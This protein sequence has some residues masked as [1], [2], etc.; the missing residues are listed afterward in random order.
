MCAI[1]QQHTQHVSP[2]EHS[3]N[4]TLNCQ[5]RQTQLQQHTELSVQTNSYNNTLNCQPRQ[6]QLQQHTEQVS[7]YEH[8]YNKL[9]LTNAQIHTLALYSDSPSAA[10]ATA[11]R[12]RLNRRTASYSSIQRVG[13]G[14]L[15]LCCNH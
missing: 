3:Y 7:P 14:L 2:D 13:Q 9:A 11:R 12:S 15:K 8:S 10:F 1:W 5:P 6:T 4:N